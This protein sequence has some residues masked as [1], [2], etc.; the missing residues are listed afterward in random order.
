VYS[1][2]RLVNFAV[3]L[4]A[5]A[6]MSRGAGSQMAD[7]AGR[8]SGIAVL[9]L[10]PLLALAGLRRNAG[11]GIR[12]AGLVATAIFMVLLG[13]AGV[14]ALVKDDA[15]PTLAGM[16]LFGLLCI[17]N[18]W[19]LRSKGRAGLEDGQ[20]WFV[21][22]HWRG[23]YPLGVTFWIGGILTLLVQFIAMATFGPLADGLSLRGGAAIALLSY[24]LGVLLFIWQGVAVWRSSSRG[25]S[26]TRAWPM[27][28]RISVVA[29]ALAFG[30]LW[31]LLLWIPAREHALIAM[32][33]D[34]LP[35]LEARITTD[36][37][38]LLL[39]GTF[40][41][42]SADRVRRLLDG[43]PGVVT[44]ALSSP[45]GRL[46]EAAQIAA[47]VRRRGLDTYV[48]TR[49]E[50]ACTFVFLAGKERA[51]TP[52][53]R[54]GF[55]RPSFA[56]LAP[57]AFDPATRGMIETYR[58][59]GI[60]DDFLERIASTP[61]R[62]MWYPSR[63][64]LEEAGVINRVSL[65]GETSAIG[66]L[67]VG[68]REELDAAFRAV[69]M[70]TA[71]ERHFPGT[72][73]AA[74]RAAWMERTQGGIDSAVSNAARA[75]VGERYPKILAAA[76]ERALDGF[77]DIMVA[78]M[79]AAKAISPEA[80]GL[81]LAGRLNV[82]QVL[83][84]ELVRREQDWAL[85]VLRAETLVERAPVDAEEFRITMAEATSVLPPEVMDVVASPEEFADRPQR[86]CDS[87]IA[88]YDR[89]LALP[90]AERHLLLRGMFQAGS[91]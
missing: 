76:D 8:W 55:H 84:P 11:Q 51:A 23:E 58:G 60:P 79:K 86:Q 46:H 37:T 43:N 16:A 50:S 42:G 81:L 74:V 31:V 65:G 54:I 75:V 64:E 5:V 87:T 1:L 9:S 38:V 32:G 63:S 45:G 15:L 88:L 12:R 3:I 77:T 62:N 18:L 41:S 72:I 49:C 10:V 13:V 78:Q 39:H 35:P 28:A 26:G 20:G 56:G 2:L 4:I 48:D 25:R 80:C 82:A 24:I 7:D 90:P 70:M 89:V 33:R 91:L 83:N 34:P 40:G 59:A 47:L 22:R 68:S 44:V 71:L 21:G 85:Q 17:A 69:P 29:G 61:A 67:A 53:A 30:C 66:F 52:N 14:N 6:A 27:L 73:E 57:V 36:D 19:G